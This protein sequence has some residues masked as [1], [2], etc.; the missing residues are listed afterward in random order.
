M[1]TF[2]TFPRAPITEALLDIQA[3]LPSTTD[4]PKLATFQEAIKDRFPE[5]RER[6][7]WSQGFQ[8]QIGKTP[9]I[10][11]PSQMMDGYLFVSAN[12]T[13]IVQARL[14]GFTFNKLRPYESWE[15]F[16]EEAREL[17]ER[18]VALA[19]PANIT[20]IGLRYLNRIEIPLPIAD[21]RHYCLLFPEIPADIPQGLSEF[22]LRFVAPDGGTGATGVVTLTFEPPQ[23]AARVLPLI[24]D[25]DVFYQF[26][27]MPP[28]TGELWAKFAILRQL[29][30]RIFFSSVPESARSLFR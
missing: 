23:G 12:K 7:A 26:Q 28:N 19:A 3:S 17:W 29:K 4:A 13:K 11:P 9:E 22:F 21:F 5:K 14:N 2:E 10:S 25:I 18:Y 8:W 15:K 30:N 1:E 20:R 27:L 6:F 24:M 16:N